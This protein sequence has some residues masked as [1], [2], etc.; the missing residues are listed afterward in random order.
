MKYAPRKVYVIED[1]EYVE[2]TNAEFNCRKETD[3]SYE[4]KLFLPVQGCLLETDR[5]HYQ[6]FY[7]DKEHNIYL[8]KLDKKN[9]LLSID[10]FDSDDDNGTDYIQDYQ[11]DVTNT[12]ADSLMKER[13]RNCL[14]ELPDKDQFLIQQHYFDGISESDLAPVYAITQQAISKRI[15]KILSKLK[16]LLEN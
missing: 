15:Q 16:K 4:D 9:G 5:K 12:V 2:L 14:S 1:G 10:A 8:K 7:Q 3:S 6:E 13:L 11:E